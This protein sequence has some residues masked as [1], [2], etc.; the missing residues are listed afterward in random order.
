MTIYKQNDI[1]K[2]FHFKL[3][4]TYYTILNYYITCALKKYLLIKV[5]KNAIKLFTQCPYKEIDM[6]FEKK[7][8]YMIN[9]IVYEFIKKI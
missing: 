8:Y 2:V 4:R 3:T 5:N 6:M 9:Q 1:K 7:K